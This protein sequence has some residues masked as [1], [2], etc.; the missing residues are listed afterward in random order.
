MTKM[1]PKILFPQ[2]RAKKTEYAQALKRWEQAFDEVTRASAPAD[3]A[4]WFVDQFHDGTAIFSRVC[5]ELRKGVVVNQVLLKDDSLV[6][7]AW[8]SAFGGREYDDNID[9]LTIQ[10]MM[11]EESIDKAKNLLK[12]FVVD[13]LSREEMERRCAVETQMS[14]SVEA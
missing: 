5:R 2:F 6:F 9:R 14:E 13:G 10:C 8:M 7:R 1:R 11:T 3:W 4:E 12:A